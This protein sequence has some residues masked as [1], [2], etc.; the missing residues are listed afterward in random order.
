MSIIGLSKM[1]QARHSKVS[2]IRFFMPFPDFR[3]FA[4]AKIGVPEIR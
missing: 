4:I 3:Y 2:G 1:H